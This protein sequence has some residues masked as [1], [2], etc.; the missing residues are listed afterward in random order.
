MPT[1][2][3]ALTVRRSIMSLTT[4]IGH[5]AHIDRNGVALSGGAVE[6][7]NLTQKD[8]GSQSTKTKRTRMT[9]KTMGIKM[10]E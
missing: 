9:Q 1:R 7:Q 2:S 6:R 5:A 10:V 4:L 8:V 3:T